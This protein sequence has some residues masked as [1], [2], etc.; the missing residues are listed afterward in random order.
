MPLHDENLITCTNQHTTARKFWR[1]FDVDP[2]ALCCPV[3]GSLQDGGALEIAQPDQARAIPPG[4]IPIHID[5]LIAKVEAWQRSREAGG[6]RGGCLPE[7]V[8]YLR[9]YSALLKVV[10]PDVAVADP[11]IPR[12]QTDPIPIPIAAVDWQVRGEVADQLSRVDDYVIRKHTEEDLDRFALRELDV[13]SG[14]DLDRLLQP[15]ERSTIHYDAG[16][17]GD[18]ARLETDAEFRERGKRRLACR[19]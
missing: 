10:E 1:L 12:C 2:V 4:R 6:Y 17:R 8:A 7:V 5:S 13:A 9:E 16:M 11:I 3:C 15:L 14:A 19:R 18:V